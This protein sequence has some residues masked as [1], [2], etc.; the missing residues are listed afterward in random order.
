[1]KKFD[2]LIA[3]GL[4]LG[5]MAAAQAQQSNELERVQAASPKFVAAVS[6]RDINAIDA[7]WAHESY[8]S[9]IGPL[10]TKVVVGWD[11]V[12][13][14]WQMRFGQLDRVRISMDEPHIRVNGEAAWV[15]GMEKIELLR[16]DG[17]TISFDAFVTNVFEKAG[18]GFWWHIRRRQFSSRQNN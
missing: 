6:G 17:K 16:K 3:M 14:A 12:R 5:A 8:A 2:M 7:V 15:V 18:S 1:M 4:L 13:Q 11:G 9:F 10:S